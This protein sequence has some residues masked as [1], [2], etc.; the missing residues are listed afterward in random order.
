MKNVPLIINLINRYRGT[1]TLL[2]ATDMMVYHQVNY[3]TI[4]SDTYTHKSDS[5]CNWP[6]LR[7]NFPA[8]ESL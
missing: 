1:Y 6:N 4:Y 8:C 2:N 3:V 5:H 7:P